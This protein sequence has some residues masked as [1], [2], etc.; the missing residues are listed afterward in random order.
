MF[1]QLHLPEVATIAASVWSKL[2]WRHIFTVIYT[3]SATDTGQRSEGKQEA[4]P[5]WSWMKTP[6][7]WFSPQCCLFS[8]S[9]ETPW[10][11]RHWTA[12]NTRTRCESVAVLTSLR[13]EPTFI[14]SRRCSDYQWWIGA[15]LLATL[16]SRASI[17]PR[18]MIRLMRKAQRE[19]GSGW[20]RMW[21]S[22]SIK[23]WNLSWGLLKCDI[24]FGS[25]WIW[26]AG[27]VAPPE[28]A[29]LLKGCSTVVTII[30]CLIELQSLSAL[31]CFASEA[32]AF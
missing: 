29:T 12:A 7:R 14:P 31:I 17:K 28:E 9:A 13:N 25:F 32:V 10:S 6:E 4:V 1:E 27:F 20:L 23:W 21:F 19:R 15:P 8:V 11:R 16:T 2:W 30:P 24:V 26:K 18:R 3:W 22:F 5:G